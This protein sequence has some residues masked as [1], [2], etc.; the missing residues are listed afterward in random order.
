MSVYL[1]LHSKSTIDIDT[2]RPLVVIIACSIG[3]D[4]N[5]SMLIKKHKVLDL[6]PFFSF[7]NVSISISYVIPVTTNKM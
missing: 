3:S 1:F 2:I 6:K 7:I 5:M 4:L